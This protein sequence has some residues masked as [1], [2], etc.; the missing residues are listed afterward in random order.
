MLTAKSSSIPISIPN[1][2]S[3]F[4]K[5]DL[6]LQS[7]L[8]ATD[9]QRACYFLH[10]PVFW[11]IHCLLLDDDR[12]NRQKDVILLLFRDVH[13]W[14]DR[15]SS[16]AKRVVRCLGDHVSLRLWVFYALSKYTKI[17]NYSKESQIL[18]YI[19]RHCLYIREN[20]RYQMQITNFPDHPPLLFNLFTNN[21]IWIN[22]ESEILT[23]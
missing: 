6:S 23:C 7:G 8:R 19:A 13:G 1:F 4:R 22:F 10:I 17:W 12:P 21:P 14:N 5:P 20:H 9:G 11:D 3:R 2:N 15:R 16:F 18:S